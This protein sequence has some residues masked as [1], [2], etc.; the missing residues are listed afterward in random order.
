MLYA[1]NVTQQYITVRVICRFELDQAG[2]EALIARLPGLTILTFDTIDPPQVL[3]YDYGNSGSI[4]LPE[5]SP[6][7]ALLLLVP[8]DE[9][10]D[11]PPEASR[12]ILGLFSK[13]ETAEA[14]SIAIRQLARGEAYL[15]PALALSLLHRK[16]SQEDQPEVDLN[17]LTE[18]EREVLGLLTEGLS[19]KAIAARLYLSV[20]TVDGHL[21]NL[22][23][24][25]GVRS[26][27]EAM[28]LAI[29]HN[30]VPRIR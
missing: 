1:V 16:Q 3:V 19:N 24:R 22:Y 14:L 20:R 30:L 4:D 28:R 27:T 10:P 11:L 9:P 15:S 13:N 7:T 12:G 23:A 18:R 29:E 6:Q 5:R 17:S 26:R 2:L 8:G 25:L 21:S